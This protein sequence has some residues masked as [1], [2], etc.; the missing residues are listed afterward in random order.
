MDRLRIRTPV[1]LYDRWILNETRNGNH[2]RLGLIGRELKETFKRERL[3]AGRVKS[4]PQLENGKNEVRDRIQ[5][6]NQ[7]LIPMVSI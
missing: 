5:L 3:N 6:A 4:A 1:H 7:I 2:H